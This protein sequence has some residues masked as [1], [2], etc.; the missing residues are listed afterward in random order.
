MRCIEQWFRTIAADWA[1][2][3]ALIWTFAI[4]KYWNAYEHAKRTQCV[5]FHHKCPCSWI[6][7]ND[8][9]GHTI[10]LAQ[11][12]RC[13][14]KNHAGN[15]SNAMKLKLNSSETD[16]CSVWRI[17]EQNMDAQTPAMVSLTPICSCS[18]ARTL[19]EQMHRISWANLTKHR[20][21]P[22]CWPNVLL[23]YLDASLNVHKSYTIHKIL[24]VGRMVNFL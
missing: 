12:V 7:S 3:A 11:W 16:V 2:T 9:N 20:Q 22:N 6:T 1:L 10:V 18:L 23:D 15:I 21:R 13:G 5:H 17:C 14:K 4:C 8:E 19:T 24:F